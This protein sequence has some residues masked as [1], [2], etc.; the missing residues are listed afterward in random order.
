MTGRFVMRSSWVLL[1][2]IINSVSRVRWVTICGA[3][4]RNEKLPDVSTAL[5]AGI[6]GGALLG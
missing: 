1:G 2:T 5:V 4:R 6:G 3:G